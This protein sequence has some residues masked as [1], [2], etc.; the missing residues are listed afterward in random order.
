M[1]GANDADAERDLLA[2]GKVVEGRKDLIG[3]LIKDVLPVL[4]SRGEIDRLWL[5]T[6]D[7]KGALL[8]EGSGGKRL[9]VC[10]KILLGSSGKHLRVCVRCGSITED[11]GNVKKGLA[12]G[13]SAD[14][15][16]VSLRGWILLR[17]R[18]RG[19]WMSFEKSGKE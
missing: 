4:R 9:D 15:Y 18:I 10:N 7:F 17:W 16:K 14:D 6:G 5:Y 13:N 1:T 12:E 19:I 2:T 8:E 3:M 11:F